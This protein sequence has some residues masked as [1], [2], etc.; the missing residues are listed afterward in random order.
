MRLSKVYIKNFRSIKEIEISFS[1][2]CRILVGMNE[3]GKSNILDAL[4]LLDESIK[5]KNTDLREPG[6]NEPP[7]D[8][9][10]VRFIFAID[11]AD[12]EKLYN[13]ME[14]DLL[15]Q[16]LNSEII[17][18]NKTPLNLRQFIETRTEALF[19]AILTD[20]TKYPSAWNL[21]NSY[22]AS[23][24]LFIVNKDVPEGTQIQLNSESVPVSQ[25]DIIGKEHVEELKD[26]VAPCKASDI[27]L[28]FVR[29]IRA[30]MKDN[31]ISCIHWK[32]DES[33]LLPSQ[34]EIN[35]FAENPDICKPLQNMFALAG[36]EKIKEE[37]LASQKKGA[38]GL[39][40]LLNRVSDAATEHIK[41]IWKEYKD[42]NI[43]LSV[44]GLNIDTAVVDHFNYFSFSARSDG[45]K[46]FTSF[47]LMV[48][49]QARKNKLTNCLYLH[50]EPDTGI[51]PSGA[52]Y[53]RDELIKISD[54]NYVV[55][56]TH[57][58]FMID[59]DRIDRHYIVKKTAENTTIEEA[60]NSNFVDEEVLYNAVGYSIF[61]TLKPISII[62]EGWRDKKLFRIA[63]AK[64]KKSKKNKIN[65]ENIGAC[66]AKGVK[67]IKN[68]SS[69]LDV[70]NRKWIVIS[71]SDGP[72]KEQQK[73]YKGDGEWYRYDEL[74]G[75][76]ITAEDF[77]KKTAIIRAMEIVRH[78]NPAL[79]P[80]NE[81]FLDEINRISNI[82]SW[83]SNA[84]ISDDAQKAAIN[85]IKEAIFNDLKVEDVEEKY[86]S[87][88]IPK[89]LEKIYEAS[90]NKEEL[91]L[92]KR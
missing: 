84:G 76:S 19:Q 91:D 37:I 10:F 16:N 35:A 48:S 75:T 14:R 22:S 86:I 88:V 6:K 82:K 78:E 27:N 60:S 53:L 69:I 55:F 34:I 63:S 24:N 45:F 81:E 52:K 12:R 74:D 41:S 39:R 57:S 25:W 87:E 42:I 67:D 83:L 31:P 66:H 90:P 3:S 32:Y 23:P 61:E 1:P 50:D 18:N 13:R 36:V 9:A 29:G 51:H 79:Q 72:A 30:L 15:I 58:I 7:V 85:N 47:L 56:S 73:L 8:S 11:D 92:A 70:A 4:S 89:I 71:D 65:I 44:N 28:M 5:I 62:F 20:K 77:V 33:F 64:I 80:V 17:Y 38:N 54:N 26:Y 46:R 59:K 49:A 40:N 68:I 2:R 21:G 43:V